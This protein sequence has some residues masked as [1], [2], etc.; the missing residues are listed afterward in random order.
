MGS[1]ILGE[2]QFSL[3][4]HLI[5]QCAMHMVNDALFSG[6]NPLLPF[7]A[8][9]LGLNYAET[10]AIK[11]AYW[12]SSGVLQLP[13]GVAAERWSEQ[14]LLALGSGWVG[15]GL[16]AMTTA[17]AFAPLFLLGLVAGIGGN[18]QHPIATTVVSRLFRG[19]KR[20]NA[21]GVLNFAGDFG[22]MLSPLIVGLV[23]V[24]HGWRAA[25]LTI[26]IIGAIFAILYAIVMPALP[27][28]EAGGLEPSTPHA[29]AAARKGWGI[30]RPRMYW[31]LV[32]IGMLDSGSRSVAL[33][34]VP[35]VLAAK[36]LDA[37]GVSSY[38]ILIYGSGAAGKL[39]SGPLGNRFGNA[40]TIMVIEVCTALTIIGVLAVPV[41]FVAIA[42]VPLGLALYGTTSILYA[43]VPE[44]VHHD[45]QG[46]GFGLYFTCSQ[47][48]TT[49]APVIYGLAG[50]AFG[51]STAMIAASV[52]AAAIVPGV[53]AARH[54]LATEGQRNWSPRA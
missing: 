17:T 39:V 5:G 30:A 18:T 45:R 27:R 51:L 37:A 40:W 50:D 44:F 1:L 48:A 43:L 22:K 54:H 23:A 28:G 41:T 53:F 20:P 15:L 25:C 42:L 49:L 9:D 10:G 11:A 46:R 36:G 33:A 14:M 21:I 7:I 12:G 19:P 52:T 4:A 13:A 38:F 6:I 34:F 47:A 26:G 32:T 3:R 24:Q 35:F 8:A 2:R 16:I 29:P 31:F